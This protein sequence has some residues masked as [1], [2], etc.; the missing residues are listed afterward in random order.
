[1]SEKLQVVGIERLL[2]AAE[3]LRHDGDGSSSPLLGAASEVWG[4]MFD[5]PSWPT[6]LKV[7]A[8]ELQTSLFRYGPIKDTIEKSDHSE[9]LQL[10]DKL[11]EF[12][13]FATRV[14]TAGGSQH[15]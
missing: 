4:A 2:L 3:L 7:A 5:L 14:H 6:E 8:V 13:T 9:R 10:R 11:L 15:Q 12:I 1:M